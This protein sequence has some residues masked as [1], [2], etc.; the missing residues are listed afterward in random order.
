MSFLL[1]LHGNDAR[2]LQ[3][4]ISALEVAAQ[5]AGAGDALG[6]GRGGFCLK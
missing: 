4:E 6:V 2:D 3:L 1:G 5:E